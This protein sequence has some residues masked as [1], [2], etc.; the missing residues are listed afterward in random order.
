MAASGLKPPVHR[1]VRSRECAGR[2]WDGRI[3]ATETNATLGARTLLN[4]VG[5]STV[6]VNNSSVSSVSSSWTYDSTYFH[7]VQLFNHLLRWWSQRSSVSDGL[8]NNHHPAAV[9]DIHHIMPLKQIWEW[10]QLL[11]RDMGLAKKQQP[12]QNMFA[13]PTIPSIHR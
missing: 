8:D 12:F 10:I 3:V 13:I 11:H 9:H 7:D 1:A 5:C 4:F 6:L 2:T